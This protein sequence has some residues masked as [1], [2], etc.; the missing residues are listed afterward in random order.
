MIPLETLE[1]IPERD[2]DIPPNI[3]LQVDDR[4]GRLGE[5]EIKIAWFR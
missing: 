1:M 3:L 5:A 4:F 2:T